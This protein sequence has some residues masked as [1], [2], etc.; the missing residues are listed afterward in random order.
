MTKALDNKERK[1]LSGTGAFGRAV[2]RRSIRKAPKVRKKYTPQPGKAPR[3]HVHPNTGLRLILFAYEPTRGS[4]VIGPLKFTSSSQRVAFR[5][6]SYT[7]STNKT[8]PQLIN[9]GGS[10]TRVTTYRSGHT[11]TKSLYYRSFPFRDLA[12]PPTI[13]KLKELTRTVE[14]K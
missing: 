14:F 2:M 8:I 3:Y 1:V 10:V 5:A 7:Q 6:R 9:D 12:M 13:E 11:Y 4:V